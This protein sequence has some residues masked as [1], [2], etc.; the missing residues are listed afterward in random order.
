[1]PS[2]GLFGPMF[3][4]P[5]ASRA[6]SGEAWLRAILDV[7]T[8]LARAQARAGFIAAASAT[9]IAEACAQPELA[10]DE[11]AVA[12][13]NSA[14]PVVPFVA[15]MRKLL[16]AEVA[17]D[18]HRG[19]TSQDIL[20][21]AA[22][23][24]AREAIAL[25]AADLER[26]AAAASA[27]AERHRADPILGRTLMQPA[28]PTTFGL[29]AAGWLMGIVEA[30][31]GLLSIAG[32]RLA[33]Q[34]GGA[35]GTLASMGDAAEVIEEEMARSLNLRVAPAPWHT[36]RGRIAEFAA[37][38]GIAAGAAGKIALDV[39]LLAQGEVREA[40]ERPER[41]R[42]GSSAMPHKQNAVGAI[43]VSA[44]V[45]HAHGLVSVL[46]SSMVQEHERG[47]GAWQAEWSAFNSLIEV[48]AAAAQGI[49]A[50]L[51]GLEVDTAAMR[52]N[53]E[54]AG[55]LPFAESVV[56]ALSARIDPSD[57]RDA[58]DTALER[59]AERGTGL[60]EELLADAGVMR[61]FTVA[62]LGA[63][64]EPAATFGSANRFIDRALAAFAASR[65][66]T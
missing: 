64:F 62:E 9:A 11:I 8:A 65:E 24:V 37:A 38:L 12:A 23:L 35:S 2:D 3:T 55:G 20:D 51:E 28:V 43:R 61:L 26:A 7:E 6:V 58:V 4:T 36:Q 34:L 47:A 15:A 41:G 40:R 50:L 17:A 48:T 57:A 42:G 21:T 16:P 32:S 59:V 30:R 39:T 56:A 1:M 10:I 18:F 25:I 27:L 60:F 53:L 13:L 52:D 44:C 31:A 5:Q 66:D 33:L 14:Q 63:M 19:A 45:R 22:M 29:K 46:F 54:S 49:A